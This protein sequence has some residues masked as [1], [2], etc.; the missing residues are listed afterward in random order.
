MG[1]DLQNTQLSR[2]TEIIPFGKRDPL[3]ILITRRTMVGEKPDYVH[4][5]SLQPHWQLCDDPLDYRF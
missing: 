2:K 1:T 4:Y 3:A 5:N